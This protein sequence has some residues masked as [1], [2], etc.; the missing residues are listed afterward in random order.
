MSDSFMNKLGEQFIMAQLQNQF[1]P[2][3]SAQPAAQPPPNYHQYQ[4]GGG[5]NWHPQPRFQRGGGPSLNEQVATLTKAVETLAQQHTQ[6]PA[7]QNLTP[8]M[9]PMQT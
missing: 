4:R 6:P 3:P 8:Q 9:Q 7:Q 2:Q 5:N 1:Q